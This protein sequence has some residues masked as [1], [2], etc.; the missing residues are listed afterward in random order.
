MRGKGDWEPSQERS[1]VVIVVEYYTVS[2][3]FA[4]EYQQW[5]R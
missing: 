4:N 5:P 3:K 2:N 1:K